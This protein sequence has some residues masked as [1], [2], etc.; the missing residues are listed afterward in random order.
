GPRREAERDG[1]A[2]QVPVQGRHAQGVFQ[3]EDLDPDELGDDR[4]DA[5]EGR[6]AD[7][8]PGGAIVQQVWLCR[9]SVHGFPFA[10]G[11]AN[12][13]DSG[14]PAPPEMM[15][16]MAWSTVQS[17]GVIFSTGTISR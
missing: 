4:V 8:Q 11:G 12:G 14:A 10:A 16:L 2:E 6:Q 5:E 1:L 15:K 7:E 13:M 3:R 17:V 9:H